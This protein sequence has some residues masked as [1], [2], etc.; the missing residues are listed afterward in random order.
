MIRIPKF[1][2]RIAFAAACGAVV[3]GSVVMGCVACVL[4]CFFVAWLG[5]FAY[6]LLVETVGG[7]T[8]WLASGL[9]WPW[10]V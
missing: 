6:W 4:L 7:F 3:F 5:A 9:P 8:D 1:L 10:E 2:D